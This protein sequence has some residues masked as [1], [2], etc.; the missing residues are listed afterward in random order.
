MLIATKA[1]TINTANPEIR[2]L[3]LTCTGIIEY[4]AEIKKRIITVG[5]TNT[6]LFIVSLSLKMYKL[7]IFFNS[8]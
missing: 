6:A 1:Q 4:M 7:N 5:I 8:Y 3:P 2:K